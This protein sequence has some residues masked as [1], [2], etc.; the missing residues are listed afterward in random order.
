MIEDFIPNPEF[1][2]SESVRA[3][4]EPIGKEVIARAEELAPYETGALERSIVGE[5]VVEGGRQIF[6][7]SATDFK[8]DWQEFGTEQQQ[9]QPFLGPA[10]MQIIG[11]LH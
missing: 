9:A 3:S 10:A 7:I 4:V 8:A 1:V 5:W 6:R 2:R 11:N